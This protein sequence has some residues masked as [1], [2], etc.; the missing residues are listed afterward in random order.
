MAHMIHE[1]YLKTDTLVRDINVN[2][3][4]QP[5]PVVRRRSVLSSHSC[6]FQPDSVEERDNRTRGQ[7]VNSKEAF[8]SLK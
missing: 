6:C 5:D 2:V 1:C 3:G 8:A 7:S 4:I